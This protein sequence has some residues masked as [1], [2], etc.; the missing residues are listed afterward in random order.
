L[1]DRARIAAAPG[2]SRAT[3]LVHL[4]GVH[5]SPRDAVALRDALEPLY[6]SPR[7]EPRLRLALV[8]GLS[9][10]W[11]D[12]AH[13]DEVRRSIADWFNASH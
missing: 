9:H 13:A 6:M 7:D 8:E 4:A 2:T 5:R 10:G 3:V 11:A 1:L 12:S